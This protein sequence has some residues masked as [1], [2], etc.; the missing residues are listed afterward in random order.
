MQP[1]LQW[2]STLIKVKSVNNTI[3]MNTF[4]QKINTGIAL[5]LSLGLASCDKEAQITPD[6]PLGSARVGAPDDIFLPSTGVPKNYLLTRLGKFYLSYYADGRLSRVTEGR[7][8][9]G[10]GNTNYYEDYT[11][12]AGPNNTSTIHV[13]SSIFNRVYID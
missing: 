4:I 11:Y 6:R 1:G 5:Y 2:F 3:Q 12:T 13:I 7:S 9:I 8:K 10:P